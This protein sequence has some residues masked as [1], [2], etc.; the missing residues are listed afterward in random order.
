MSVCRFL[1]NKTRSVGGILIFVFSVLFINV[2]L[3]GQAVFAENGAE[4]IEGNVI[5]KWSGSG[6]SDCSDPMYGRYGAGCQGYSWAFYASTG[7]VGDM[8]F[9]TPGLHHA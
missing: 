9:H 5:N 7:T 8:M 2:V 6:S 1:N 3:M 4:I